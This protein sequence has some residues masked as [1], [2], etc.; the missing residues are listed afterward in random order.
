MRKFAVCLFFAIGLSLPRPVPSAMA[1]LRIG[2]VYTE[3]FPEVEAVLETQALTTSRSS[4]PAFQDLTLVEDGQPTVRAHAVR[5]F[6]E[7]GQGLAIVVAIDVSRTMAG[8]PLRETRRALLSLLKDL[9]PR[10]Q[11]ALVSFADDV[12]VE[13]P[14]GPPGDQ[15]RARVNGLTPRGRITE[16]YRALFQSLSLFTP[17]LPGRRRLLVISDG[18]DEG[19]AYSL[20]DVIELAQEREVPVDAIGLTRIDPKYLS[21]LERLSELTGGGFSPANGAVELE[22]LVRKGLERLHFTPVAMFTIRNLKRD[23][24]RHR[25]GIQWRQGSRVLE[26]ETRVTLVRS[27]GS[28]KITQEPTKGYTGRQILLWG[29]VATFLLLTIAAAI[30]KG[31][32][33]RRKMVAPLKLNGPAGSV[34]QS[35][36]HQEPFPLT[37]DLP[38]IAIPP[39]RHEVPAPA[40]LPGPLP[41]PHRSRRNTQIRHDFAAPTKERPT[42]LLALE[43][44]EKRFPV[45]EDPFWIGAAEDNHLVVEQD[46]FLSSHHAC[47]RFQEGTLLLYDN[48]STNGTFVNSERLAELPRP[49]GLGDRIRVGHSTFVVLAP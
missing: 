30:Q 36:P 13:M 37:E 46:Q 38:L 48:R 28:E 40:D 33:T 26:G 27:T 2:P 19:E 9:Q 41:R 17:D 29:A 8:R 35:A 47:I 18:K 45:E 6:R 31:L 44:Q 3:N 32:T 12:R 21:N 1:E 49:L 7:T 14:F 24:Q 42:A 34:L 20:D 16:L 11:V 4:L 10:D 23:D 5:T 43:D 15:I 39:T 25:L 22:S